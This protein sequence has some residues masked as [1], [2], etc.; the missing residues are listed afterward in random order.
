[1][2][3]YSVPLEPDQL[4]LILVLIHRKF[5]QRQIQILQTANTTN[6]DTCANVWILRLREYSVVYSVEPF[7]LCGGDLDMLRICEVQKQGKQWMSGV[8][9]QISC[10]C[11]GKKS[12][13]PSM[14]YTVPY[15]G[16]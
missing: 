6:V 15:G 13:K 5:E 3:S 10:C 8:G 4:I 7:L 11:G 14:T 12:P 1:M 16:D 9:F 2:G